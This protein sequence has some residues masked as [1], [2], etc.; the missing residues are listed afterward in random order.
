VEELA[1]A[2][3]SY[4]PESFPKSIFSTGTSAEMSRWEQKFSPKGTGMSKK[5]TC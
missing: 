3:N 2:S 1:Y 4:K 5:K